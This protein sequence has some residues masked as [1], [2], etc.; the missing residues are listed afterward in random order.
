MRP[1]FHFCC[2]GLCARGSLFERRR[3]TAKEDIT[4]YA[5]HLKK[6][7]FALTAAISISVFTLLN[8]DS[9]LG[10]E[11]P[12]TV[13]GT[14]THFEVTDST[15]P[16]ISVDSTE[17]ITLSLQSAPEIIIMHISPASEATSTTITITG[18]DPAVST[19]HYKYEDSLHNMVSFS[20]Y[21]TGIFT[22]VQDLSEEH[23][24]FIQ[25][26]GAA[27]LRIKDDSTGGH[28]PLIGTWN[29]ATKTS[30]MTTNIDIP[31]HWTIYIDDSGITF[32]GAGHTVYSNP[33][34]AG[35]DSRGK[36]GITIKNVIT[37]NAAVGIYLVNCSNSTIKGSTLS[38][39]YYGIAIQG[40]GATNNT[41]T[42]NTINSNTF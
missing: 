1:I 28:T 3:G 27:G 39:N 35:I 17:P 25:L 6:L 30:T 14:G 2:Q 24:V 8:A 11:I 23:M 34:R 12:C 41:V 38:N 5:R 9:V 19:A 40:T 32:D 21:G 4:M 20:T 18:F 22:Y 31:S 42:E 26:K 15:C 36:T 37:E 33:A 10:E 7:S 13:E 16:N 29:S